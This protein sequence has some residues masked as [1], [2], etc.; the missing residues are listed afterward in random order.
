MNYT[1]AR[2]KTLVLLISIFL[3]TQ[4]FAVTNS[5]SFLAQS[6]SLTLGNATGTDSLRGPVETAFT[7]YD[8]ASG[9]PLQINLGL[10]SGELRPRAGTAGVFETDFYSSYSDLSS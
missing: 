2:M 8:G 1:L 6:Q 10:V 7:T 4:A 3:T 5:A 9:L